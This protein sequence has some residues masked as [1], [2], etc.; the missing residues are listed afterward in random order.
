MVRAIIFLRGRDAEY[1]DVLLSEDSFMRVCGPC[2]SNWKK[3]WIYTQNLVVE[4]R[5]DC[6]IDTTIKETRGVMASL[7]TH[8]RYS[9][10]ATR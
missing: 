5:T 4:M 9:G 2:L 8:L 6:L 10:D 7:W 3:L 1:G